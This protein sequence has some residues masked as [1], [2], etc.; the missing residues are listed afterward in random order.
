MEFFLPI[1]DD[2]RR[3]LARGWLLLG[4]LSLLGSGLFSVLLVLAR[5]PYV[6]G[7][8]PWADFFH[9][10]LVVHV[11]LSVLVW[12]LAFGGMLW[13]LNSSA[14]WIGAGRLA[15][16]LA[17]AGA[18]AMTLAPFTGESRPLMS[19]YI[20][21]LQQPVFLAGLVLFALGFGL[22]ALRAMAAIPPV[23]VRMQGAAA[24]RFGL[25]TAAVSAMLA[26]IA[27]GW[28]WLTLPPGLTGRAYYEL[29]FW[30]GGHVLQF[31]YTL[32]L[33]VVWLWL[34][35]ASGVRLS[36][37]P[38]VALVFF[39][40]GLAT[41]FV[42]PII[43]YSFPVTSPEHIRL[44]TWLM[45]YGGSLA[46]LPLSLA[47]TLGVLTRHRVPPA[48]RPAN[49][50]LIASILLFGSGGVIGFLI[51]GVDVTIPAHYHG[52]IV[53]ITLAFMGL[54]YHLL[55]RLG[56]G[57]PDVKWA[58]RQPWIYGTGQLLH[59]SGL[60]WS[61][62]YGVPR[63]VAG[64]AQGLDTVERIAAMGLMGLGGLIAILGGL[65]FLVIV[66]RALRRRHE[67]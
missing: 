31:T 40:F 9:T 37:T 32:L 48:E 29:L 53:G 14:H 66:Y 5:T 22:L 34:A 46:T 51:R 19:N 10:A 54:T 26:L 63:K 38:R 57:R 52:C 27:F 62:G 56:L 7:I 50:A 20:P 6:Q 45:Q 55:P 23:G 59:V 60:L 21:V 28:T 49:A 36:I 12:F 35:S 44:F 2:A 3:T 18:A 58:A 47:V 33:L 24:L 64:A 13:S 67:A 1:P 65:L 4:V 11:D 8:I 41:V 42:T 15:L 30:G 39:G 17:A 25:N 61:G 16:W 43:Y